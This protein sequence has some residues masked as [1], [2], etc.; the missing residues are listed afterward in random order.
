MI[1]E[2][3]V[4]LLE[5]KIKYSFKNQK[6]L[7]QAITHS[8]FANERKINRQA[9][10]ERLEFLGDAVLELV[11]SS[12]L[13]KMYTDMP[14]GEM[15]KTR[16]S[17]VCEQSLAYCAKDIEIAK[18]IRLG[19]GEES[20]GG[21]DRDSIIADVMEAIIGALYLDGGF[22]EASDFIHRFIL[23]DW[24]K[25]QLFY[26]SKTLLQEALQKNGQVNIRYDLVDEV[27]PD[28]A[29]QFT[30]AARVNGKIV[31]Q[32]IGK[33]KKAAEQ[34]AAYEALLFLKKSENQE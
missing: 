22:D 1:I 26:D 12:F 5:D 24:E 27:G 9:D 3:D 18:F 29:K 11:T 13:F 34:L 16:A 21:R 32:G 4:G 28:H 7:E 20:T 31:G 14:E 30:I 17:L 6:Y 8:S 25:K 19:K 2:K 15:T 33:T 10:Y 23:S